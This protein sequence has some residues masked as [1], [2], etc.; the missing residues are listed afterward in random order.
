MPRPPV[1]PECLRLTRRKATEA[2]WACRASSRPR[3]NYTGTTLN[4]VECDSHPSTARHA[5]PEGNTVKS[6]DARRCGGTPA[7]PDADRNICNVE[8]LKLE[9]RDDE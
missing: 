3:R 8:S 5:R 9:S 4:P 1:M 2:R 7:K 6:S